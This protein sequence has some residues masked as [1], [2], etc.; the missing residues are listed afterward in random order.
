MKAIRR[1]WFCLIVIVIGV[2]FIATGFAQSREDVQAVASLGFD[3]SQ[4]VTTEGYAPQFQKL[5]IAGEMG[6][7]PFFAITGLRLQNN[8]SYSALDP[9]AVAG[10]N[11]SLERG[12][13]GVRLPWLGLRVGRFYPEA[14]VVSPYSLFNTS[15]ELGLRQV[16]LSAR[17]ERVFF[18]TRAMILNQNSQNG[19]PDRGASVTSW[20]VRFGRFRIGYQDAAVYTERVFDFSYFANP[21][22]SWPLQQFLNAEGAPWSRSANDNSIMGFFLDY[23]GSEFYG[24]SQILVDDF[25]NSRFFKPDALQNPDKVA[26]SIGGHTDLAGGRFGLYHAGATKYT[27]QAYGDGS[28]PASAT[29]TKY[30]YTLFP[31]VQYTVDSETR[32]IESSDNYLGYVHGENNLAFMLSYTGDFAPGSFTL[33]DSLGVDSSLEITVSGAKSPGNPWHQYTTFEQAG[34]GTRFLDGDRVETELMI[35]AGVIA[36]SGDWSLSLSLMGGYV[37]NELQLTDIP[38]ELVGPANRIPY[39]SPSGV[40]RP[41]AE[42]RI[43]ISYAIRYEAG[44]L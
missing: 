41:I 26:W 6:I 18:E 44:K 10:Y 15:A 24:Y 43:G 34:E 2:I 35:N 39:L 17:G 8:G 7:G 1:A 29:D 19:Y 28:D 20:G 37:F 42:A 23:S 27:F 25:N 31:D 33:V 21:L 22:P 12:G 11:G 5:L 36:M 30:G 4:T 3:V 16:D 13:F 32:V 38:S 9:D 40:N 14:A